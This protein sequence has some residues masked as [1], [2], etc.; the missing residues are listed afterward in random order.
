M[1]ECKIMANNFLLKICK[2][3]L[4]LLRHLRIAC[5]EKQGAKGNSTDRVVENVHTSNLP[6]Q[7]FIFR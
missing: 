2:N 1:Q 3:T 7:S 4:K 6:R 5:L